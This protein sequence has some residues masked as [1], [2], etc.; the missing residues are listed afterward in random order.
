MKPLEGRR[1]RQSGF[2]LVEV[3]FALFLVALVIGVATEVAGNAVRNVSSLKEATFAR[4]VALN[5]IDLY[6][7]ER[8]QAGDGPAPNGNAQGE[9]EMGNMQWRWEREVSSGSSAGLVEIRVAVYRVDEET[10]NEPV[11]T[12]KGYAPA[13]N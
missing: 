11:L 7:I 12:L 9:E 3:L 8:V 6:R 13:D 1:G 2:S 5:Q 10:N 4:W